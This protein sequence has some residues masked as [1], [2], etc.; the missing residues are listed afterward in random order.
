MYELVDA[1]ARADARRRRRRPPCPRSST[2]CVDVPRDH[3]NGVE[4]VVP[5][6]HHQLVTAKLRAGRTKAALRDAQ[7][8]LEQALPRSTG[9]SHRPLP[10]SA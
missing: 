6:L 9:A 2:S 5:P 8:E 10:G 7:H 4:I 1:I 3:D